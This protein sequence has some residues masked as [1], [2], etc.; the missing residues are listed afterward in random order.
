MWVKVDKFKG[1]YVSNVYKFCVC[2]FERDNIKN[3]IIQATLQVPLKSL[4]EQ[5]LYHHLLAFWYVMANFTLLM[6][7]AGLGSISSILS[8]GVQAVKWICQISDGELL[9]EMC[10]R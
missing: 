4:L 7:R 8:F 6:L 5:S 2:V 10:L 9:F 1:S 3:E